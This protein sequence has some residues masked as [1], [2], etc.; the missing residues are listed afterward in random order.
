MTIAALR[1][2]HYLKDFFIGIGIIDSALVPLLAHL[3]DTRHQAHYGSV[4]AL[5]QIAV[6]LSYSVGPIIGGEFVKVVGFPWVI[7]TVGIINFLYCPLLIYLHPKFYSPNISK[8]RD[9]SRCFTFLSEF[10]LAA[11]EVS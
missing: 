3:V 5:Q 9:N 7:R 2:Q 11:M 8:V 1:E 10:L 6:S 4:Y